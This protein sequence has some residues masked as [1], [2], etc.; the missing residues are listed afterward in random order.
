MITVLAGGVGGSKFI[1]GLANQVPPSS[2]VAVVNIGD[3]EEFYGLHV[4]PDLD[5]VTY[6]LAGLDNDVT[7]WGVKDET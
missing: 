7:G 1:R 5:T 4:S 6:V 2:I 3:D